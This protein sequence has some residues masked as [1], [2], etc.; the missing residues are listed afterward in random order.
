MAMTAPARTAI[1]I[2]TCIQ[3]QNGDIART[4]YLA[5]ASRPV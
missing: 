5:V 2:A 3:I 1:T 4:P